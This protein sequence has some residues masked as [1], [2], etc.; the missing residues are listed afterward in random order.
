MLL[1]PVF[2]AQHKKKRMRKYKKNKM[3]KTYIREKRIP[4]RL[5]NQ[6]RLVEEDQIYKKYQM[7]KDSIR[8]FQGLIAFIEGLITRKNNFLKSIQALI[9]KN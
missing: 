5:E 6:S 4:E 2:G 7:F 9:R 1:L 8:I 3:L